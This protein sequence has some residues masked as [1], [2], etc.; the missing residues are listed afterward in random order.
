MNRTCHLSFGSFPAEVAAG[1]NLF[2]V[3]AHTW[4]IAVV[5]DE[6]ID[7]DDEVWEAGLAA[8]RKVIGRN[9]DPHQYA[10]EIP[11]AASASARTR[12]LGLLGRASDELP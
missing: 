6:W 4:D 7:C 11:T 2:D 1:I 5:V 8:A 3:L 10:R 12:L 9:R